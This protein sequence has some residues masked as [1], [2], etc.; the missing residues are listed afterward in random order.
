MRPAAYECPSNQ[1]TMIWDAIQ[2]CGHFIL[3][4]QTDP[5]AKDVAADVLGP[6][7]WQDELLLEDYGGVVVSRD[8]AA[9]VWISVRREP[10]I[11]PQLTPGCFELSFSLIP[12]K[13]VLRSRVEKQLLE[14]VRR[15]VHEQGLE[16]T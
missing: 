2:N 1:T 15:V 6:A 8:N 16:E 7:M 14:D 9:F 13:K 12:P 10:R 11:L 3:L 4:F 5:R